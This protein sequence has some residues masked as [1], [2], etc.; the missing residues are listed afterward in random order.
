M[1]HL[2]LTPKS[3]ELIINY[4]TFRSFTTCLKNSLIF[5]LVGVPENTSLTLIQVT[6]TQYCKEG[7][8]ALGVILEGRETREEHP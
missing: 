7:T 8:A 4:I 1:Y 3:Y 6:V 2:E 5:F